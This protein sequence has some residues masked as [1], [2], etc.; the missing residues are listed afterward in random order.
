[1][2][3]F[4]ANH[5]VCK[6]LKINACKTTV[7]TPRYGVR[8]AQRADPTIRARQAICVIPAPKI[9]RNVLGHLNMTAPAGRSVS[10]LQQ[11]FQRRTWLRAKRGRA[12]VMFFGKFP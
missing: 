7:G 5:I 1:M 11:S 9:M 2:F 6:S 12:G 3:R 8:S 4:A 10:L